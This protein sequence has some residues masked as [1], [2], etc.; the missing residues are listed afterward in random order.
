MVALYRRLRRRLF[1]LGDGVPRLAP[2][3]LL[4]IIE[5]QRHSGSR[6]R[7]QGPEQLLRL[8]LWRGFGVLAL[9]Q[10]DVVEPGPVMPGR[11]IAVS[12]GHMMPPPGDGYHPDQ[13]AKILKMVLTNVALQGTKALVERAGHASDATHEAMLPKPMVTGR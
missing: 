11:Q 13:Q 4:S 10:E 3:G 12:I 8:L 6:P 1:H 7:G 9:Y 2:F 5:E